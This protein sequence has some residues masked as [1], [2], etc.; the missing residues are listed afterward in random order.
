MIN[1]AF[2]YIVKVESNYGYIYKGGLFLFLL[3]S[4]HSRMVYYYLSV[5]K[6]DNGETTRF[7][8]DPNEE[9]WLHLTALRQGLTFTLQALKTSPQSNSWRVNGSAKLKAWTVVYEDL[10]EKIHQKD[11]YSS[12]YRSLRQNTSF[13]ILPIKLLSKKCWTSSYFTAY[14]SSQMMTLDLLWLVHYI[15]IFSFRSFHSS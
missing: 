6:S 13:R 9:Y 3:V 5:S 7:S 8:L 1:Q 14:I 15:L 4:Y 2:F 12:E 11:T 10:L